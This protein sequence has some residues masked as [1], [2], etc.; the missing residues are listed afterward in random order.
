[1]NLKTRIHNLT[2]FIILALWHGTPVHLWPRAWHEVQA[3]HQAQV[4]KAV[5]ELK[6]AGEIYQD[7]EGYLWTKESKETET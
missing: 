7:K 5:W 2:L 3:D 1:M 6:K 4:H